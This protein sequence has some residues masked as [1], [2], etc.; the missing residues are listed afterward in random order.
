MG[1][2]LRIVP[3]GSYNPAPNLLDAPSLIQ[4]ASMRPNVRGDEIVRQYMRAL[5][6]GAAAMA[7]CG[8][9]RCVPVEVSGAAQEG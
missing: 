5:R 7:L 6:K 2:Q 1:H 8:A 4:F 9:L 3:R